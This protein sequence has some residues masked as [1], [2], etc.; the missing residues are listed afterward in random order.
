MSACFMSV[1]KTQALSNWN[2]HVDNEYYIS[3]CFI[4]KSDILLR[5]Q[6]EYPYKELNK[7]QSF[8]QLNGKIFFI[9]M[10]FQIVIAIMPLTCI[11]SHSPI[12]RR[13]TIV[14]NI[15]DHGID[16]LKQVVCRTLVATTVYWRKASKVINYLEAS[17]KW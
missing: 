16:F 5:F 17:K 3:K 2:R 1:W 12:L 13:K 14:G 9:L 7:L 6:I 15:L 8:F 10:T 4:N 11:R